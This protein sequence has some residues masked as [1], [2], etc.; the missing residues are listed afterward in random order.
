[1]AMAKVYST[2]VAAVLL[3][4]FNP[5][6]FEPRWFSAEG[7]VAEAEASEAEVQMI[8]RDF[9][10]LD[11]GWANLIATDERLQVESTG[12]TVNDGQIRDLLVGVFRLLPHTPVEIG[13]IH[14]RWHIEI[15]SIDAWHDVGHALAPKEKWQ[16][17]LTDAGLFD[18]AMEGI[19]PDDFKG[20][21]KVRIQPSSAVRSGIFI[22]VNDE[23]RLP[24]D[25][26]AVKPVADVLENLWPGAEKRSAEIK[27]LLIERLVS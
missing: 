2:Q 8:D 24:E 13:S 10:H 16:G 25:E 14:H 18:L 17:V 22:N 9:C 27:D 11:F 4:S 5:R 20:A 15:D 21:I 23:F 3:G 19:R 1:M 6:I 26:D 12:S 7:L